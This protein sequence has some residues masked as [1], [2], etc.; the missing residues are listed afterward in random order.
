MGA[1]LFKIPDRAGA[2]ALPDRTALY[3]AL[4]LG[5][6][7][8]R[9]ASLDAWRGAATRVLVVDGRLSEDERALIE[10][11]RGRLVLVAQGGLGA[12]DRAFAEDRSCLI[13]AFADA[14]PLATPPGAGV[15]TVTGL[16]AR[17]AEDGLLRRRLPALGAAPGLAALPASTGGLAVL[18]ADSADAVREVLPAV[19]DGRFAPGGSVVV[20]APDEVLED[21]AAITGVIAVSQADPRLLALI[22]EAPVVLCALGET[23]PDSA[24]PGQ[25]VRTA[26]FHGTPVVAAS[27]SS[28][29]HSAATREGSTGPTRRALARADAFSRSSGARV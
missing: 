27:V 19:R 3:P 18:V 29:R 28:A 17:A 4:Y 24:R 10:A 16:A 11:A 20:A 1:A 25:W 23:A 26:L 22:Q 9:E 7:I 12:D 21:I 13:V 5:A 14:G 6:D 15:R 2:L 8:R